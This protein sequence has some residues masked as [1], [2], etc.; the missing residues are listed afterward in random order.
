MR[1]EKMWQRLATIQWK[2]FLF[3][4]EIGTLDFCEDEL[5]CIRLEIITKVYSMVL[6]STF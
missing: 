1:E 6:I 2:G 5:T 4:L 3:S